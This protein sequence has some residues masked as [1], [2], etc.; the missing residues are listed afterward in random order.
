MKYFFY[1]KSVLTKFFKSI[2]FAYLAIYFQWWNCLINIAITWVYWCCYN[3][4]FIKLFCDIMMAK[5]KKKIAVM[6]PRK[7]SLQICELWMNVTY[8]L[9]LI[10]HLSLDTINSL[11]QWTGSSWYGVTVLLYFAQLKV[12]TKAFLSTIFTLKI[13]VWLSAKFFVVSVLADG[14]LYLIS[15]F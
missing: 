2:V 1:Q 13:W 3:F 11:V 4:C 7:P 8:N 12:P 5:P 10:M 15:V 6:I 14:Y 9:S